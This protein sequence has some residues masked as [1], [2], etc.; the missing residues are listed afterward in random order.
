V[1]WQGW[2]SHRRIGGPCWHSREQELRS[3]E[4][5]PD[6]EE[7]EELSD[8]GAEDED[9][10]WDNATREW[11]HM[12]LD[13]AREAAVCAT[14]WQEDQFVSESATQ[15]IKQDAHSLI[16]IEKGKLTKALVEAFQLEQEKVENVTCS[17][18]E[19]FGDIAGR[20]HAKTLADR[21]I[22][23][24]QPCAPRALEPPYVDDKGDVCQGYVQDMLVCTHAYE[25]IKAAC[26]CRWKIHCSHC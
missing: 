9:L 5:E 10:D 21:E 23:P 17:F 16:K 6:S 12:R 19:F 18:L 2:S 24:V 8:I 13:A 20:R 4:Q 25:P 11:T 22:K 26:G 7:T 3:V 14:G 15:Q 1:G